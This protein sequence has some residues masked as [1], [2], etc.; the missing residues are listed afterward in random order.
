MSPR[1]G[2]LRILV[3]VLTKWVWLCALSRLNLSKTP[4]WGTFR[5]YPHEGHLV[6]TPLMTRLNTVKQ[7][8]LV[9][10][11]YPGAQHTRL[12]RMWACAHLATQA[13]QTGLNN[14]DNAVRS[15]FL[16]QFGRALQD[17]QGG[18]ATP[19][20]TDRK[21]RMD[22][23]LTRATQSFENRGMLVSALRE[24]RAEL[25]VIKPVTASYVADNLWPSPSGASDQ[26]GSYLAFLEREWGCSSDEVWPLALVRLSALLHDLGHLAY[27]H[28]FEDALR[29]VG[30][31]LNHE[32]IGVMLA[33]I[34]RWLM[35]RRHER[36]DDAASRQSIA[37]TIDLLTRYLI[38]EDPTRP[39]TCPDFQNLYKTLKDGIVAG[40][41]DVDRCDC[42]ARDGTFTGLSRSTDL[43]RIIMS[44]ELRY[45]SG[46]VFYFVPNSRAAHDV[47][48]LLTDRFEIRK[49]ATCHWLLAI[50][51]CSSLRRHCARY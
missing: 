6:R 17:L 4:I 10:Y 47:R 48:R 35:A 40:T 26:Y 50:T 39:S 13:F 8:S 21:S 41:V 28:L 36:E 1:A 49:L 46:S 11:V 37:F 18:L 38:G 32:Q 24:I 20:G 45:A 5:Y 42:V 43:F 2:S 31:R 25:D 27:S 19:N 23:L 33:S 29:Q 12:L 15:F 34:L 16:E 22:S 51:V 9:H 44:F 3:L 30:I 7:M 14:A